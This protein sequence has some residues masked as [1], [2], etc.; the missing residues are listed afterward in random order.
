MSERS[1]P[2]STSDRPVRRGGARIGAGRPRRPGVEEAVFEATLRLLATRDYGDISVETL[3]ER[4]GVSRTTIYR[5]WPSKAAVVAAAVSSLY[6]ER[7][8]VPDTG[9]LSQDLVT[10]LTETYRV[11]ADGD[12][13]VLEKLVRQSGQNPELTELVRSILHARRRMYATILNRAIAR[14]EMPPEADQELLL[15]LLLGPLWFRLLVSGAPI[16]PA[17]ARSVVEIVLTGAVAGRSA[18]VGPARQPH[19]GADLV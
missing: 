6:L 2:N 5:R 15:D 19:D 3:A 7:V 1:V 18:A 4:A 14:G 17:A 11:M 16:T 8:E 13:R 12:G 9:S 10:L